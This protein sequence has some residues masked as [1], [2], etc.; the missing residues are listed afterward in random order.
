MKTNIFIFIGLLCPIFTFSQSF[1]PTKIDSLYNR[2]GLD[3]K[4][5]GTISIYQ[6]GKE[7]Y[8]KSIGF[9]D[10]ENKIKANALTKY[11]I[12]SITKTFTATIILQLVDEGKLNLDTKLNTYFPEI[13]N[14]S[15]ITIEHLLRHRSGLFNVTQSNNFRNWVKKPHTR[16]EMLAKITEN[17]PDFA[18]NEKIKYSNTNYILLSYIAE[19]IDKK[20]FTEIIESRVV[21]PLKLKRT[22]FGKK[23]NPNDNE[24]LCYYRE[25]SKW[26]AMSKLTDMNNPMGA[27]SIVSTATDVNFFYQNLFAGGLVSNTSLEKMKTPVEGMGMGLSILKF[28][29][30]PMYGHDGAIDGFNSLAVCIPNK[31][32]SVVITLNGSNT[33]ILPLMLSTLELFFE[34]YTSLQSKSSIALKS[35]DLEPYLGV[36]SSKTFPAKVTFTKK[37]ATLFAQADGQPIFKLIAIKKDVFKYDAMGIVFTFDLNDNAMSLNLEG[38]THNFIKN[39]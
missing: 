9:R 34:N 10:V 30:L 20:S 15:K 32:A 18:P 37:G 6:N 21:K 29:G 13:K 39:N 28:R 17:N 19:D 25:N 11:R 33:P 7:V 4:A 36:Y 12:G 1:N 8:Q 35:E 14:A 38:N 5:M 31:K 16:A 26:N 27:G 23:V 2:I 22:E 24:A 3:N